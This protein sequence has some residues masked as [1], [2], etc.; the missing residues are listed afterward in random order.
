MGTDDVEAIKALKANA[1][2]VKFPIPMLADPSQAIFRAYRCRDEFEDLPL[3]GAFL[4]DVEG[5][6]RFQ[7]ISA[8]P[9][10]DAAFLKAEA[11]RVNRMAAAGAK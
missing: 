7:R 2:G 9:F 3:H 5:L 11:A 8:E 1:D 4:I 10:L 6:V